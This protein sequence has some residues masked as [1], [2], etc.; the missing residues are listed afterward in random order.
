MSR[1][2][3]CNIE[4]LEPTER[5]PLCNS[6]LEKSEDLEAMYPQIHQKA[7][8]FTMILRVYSFLA[9]TIEL[10]LFTLAFFAKISYLTVLIPALFLFYIYMVLRFAVIGKSGHRA[11]IIVLAFLAVAIMVALDYIRGFNGWSINYV[12]PS[13]V[14]AVDV[15]ILLLIF[16]NKRNWQSYVMPELFMIL[17]SLAGIL[18]RALDIITHPLAIIIAL[19]FSVLLFLGTIIIGGRR[20][21]M[22]LKRR[23][24]IK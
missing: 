2:K 17:V 20:A 5:F 7:R 6:V 15:G 12:F 23:F 24:H 1:C 10:I 18:L 21:R 16:I 4:I 22:E 13:A 3:Q 9:I 11:K 19:D 8:A 14:I